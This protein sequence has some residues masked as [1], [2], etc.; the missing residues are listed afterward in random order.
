MKGA[1]DQAIFDFSRAIEKNVSPDPSDKDGIPYNRFLAFQYE[2]Y[3][4]RGYAYLKMGQH[5][6]AIDDFT[7]AL[8]DADSTKQADESIASLYLYRGYAFDG[9]G[10]REA[11]FNDFTSAIEHYT[12]PFERG[13]VINK[14][15]A[16]FN[17]G[18][19]YSEIRQHDQAIG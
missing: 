13:F 4:R 11:A 14:L 15:D 8:M 3:G 18:R 10:Q 7:T 5:E 9:S 1:Y 12:K 17:R 19:A 16:Y 6:K 2:L